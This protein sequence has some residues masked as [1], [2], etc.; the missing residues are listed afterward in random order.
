VSWQ[1]GSEARRMMMQEN[2]VTLIWMDKDQASSEYIETILSAIPHIEIIALD[3]NMPLTQA[4]LGKHPH[5]YL[6]NHYADDANALDKATLIHLM[7]KETIFIAMTAPGLAHNQVERWHQA[8]EHQHLWIVDKPIHID[9]L[10]TTI[11]D[12][13]YICQQA[14]TKQQQLDYLKPMQPSIRWLEETANMCPGD[15]VLSEMTVLFTDIRQSTQHIFKEDPIVFLRRLNDWLGLQTQRIYAFE[16]SVVKYTGDGLLAIFE[17]GARKTLAVK[18]AQRIL[19]DKN[20]TTFATGIGIADGLVMG[21]L[22]GAD[23]RYQF[24]VT[25][26]SV[27]LASR[28]CGQAKA[29]EAV[30]TAE[31]LNHVV[32]SADFKQSH[33]RVHAKGFEQDIEVIKLKERSHEND[34]E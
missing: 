14:M 8:Y 31:C 34:M 20:A 25:G 26:A 33:A 4:L 22:I 30:I 11:H 17:G 15:A 6:F 3:L 28:L 9:A 7:H 2:K 12:A 5:I 1:Q 19:Q 18:C 24:D 10:K 16:G 21:G 27:H 32:V 29:W 23:L 13:I